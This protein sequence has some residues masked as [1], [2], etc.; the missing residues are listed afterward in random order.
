MSDRVSDIA[1]LISLSPSD[2]ARQ[3]QAQTDPLT[4]E[5]LFF[6]PLASAPQVDGFAEEEWS[7]IPKLRLGNNSPNFSISYQAAINAQRLYV[8]INVKDATPVSQSYYRSLLANGDYLGVK[9]GPTRTYYLRLGSPG[10]I[11]IYYLGANDT[12]RRS[13]DIAAH[14]QIKEEGYQITKDTILKLGGLK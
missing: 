13:T 2:R 7:T 3:T 11:D 1:Q 9:L 14:W 6:Y 10:K 12:L 5:G 4:A 8:L